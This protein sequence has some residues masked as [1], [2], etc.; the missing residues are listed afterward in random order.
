MY[1]PKNSPKENANLF[2]YLASVYIKR[3][4]INDLIDYLINETDFFIAPASTRYHGSF[5]G[6]LVS[7]SLAV[8]TNFLKIAPVFNYN[9]SE[10]DNM[11]SAVIVTLFHDVCKIN[12]YSKSV[13]SVKN[14]DTGIWES[15]ECYIFDDSK[16][17]FG[18]HGAESMYIV[19]KFITLKEHEASAI[20][21]HMGSWDISKYDNVSKAYE[22]NKLAWLLHVADEASTYITGI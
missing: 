1:T 17:T 15:V 19:S 22:V 2:Q 21:H 20:Y 12:T 3:D 7:H 10:D 9:I 13:K 11:E 16:N 6:G 14:P 4:G 5:E 18:A 8:Y